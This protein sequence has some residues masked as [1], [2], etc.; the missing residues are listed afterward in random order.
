MP[1][2]FKPTVDMNLNFKEAQIILFMA[3]KVAYSQLYR[4]RSVWCMPPA[5][6]LDVIDGT[7]VE[8]VML[9][10]GKDWMP[11]FSNLKLDIMEPR[12]I[13]NCGSSEKSALWVLEWMQMEESF[14]SL[15]Y[16]VATA[17]TLVLPNNL[18]DNLTSSK[19][20]IEV[21]SFYHQQWPVYPRLPNCVM[22]HVNAYGKHMTILKRIGPPLHWNVVVLHIGMSQRYV[23]QPWYQFLTDSDFSHGDKL[24]SFY[25]DQANVLLNS[26]ERRHGFASIAKSPPLLGYARFYFSRKGKLEHMQGSTFRERGN[27]SVLPHYNPLPYPQQIPTI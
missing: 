10:Y 18:S 4:T 21:P 23:V 8:T 1:C 27:W 2:T 25:R 6:A 13:P 9:H 16:G 22:T 5:F 3:L 12:G 11:S 26:A 7:P 20:T 19:D 14:V 24:R 15:L 17:T